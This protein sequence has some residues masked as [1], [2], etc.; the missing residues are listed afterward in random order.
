[1]NPSGLGRFFQ[2][3]G[4]GAIF[5]FLTFS[6]AAPQIIEN[7]KKPPS[8]DAG[9]VMALKEVR[10]ITDEKGKFYFVQP[11]GVFTDKAGS[12]YIQ[13]NNQL[14]KFDS[15]GRF[16]GN[17]L[18]RGQGP[19]EF[20]DNLTDVVV[21]PEDILLYSSNN[22]KLVR[23]N[24]EGRLLD[25]RKFIQG[26][27]RDLLGYRN[28]RYFFLKWE[29]ESSPRITGISEDK[30]RL[31]IV[32]EKGDII[33]AP[34]LFPLTNAKWFSSRGVAINS[35]SRVTP[36]WQGDRFVF[37]FHSPDYLI[38]LL[39]LE[40][41]EIVRIF[42][43]EYDRVKYPSKPQK[44]YPE[45]LIPKYHNDLCR[46]L[47]RNDRLWAVTSTFDP[48]KGILVDIYSREGRYLDNFYLPL[49]KI[50]R[51]DL[52]YYAPMAIHD[53]FL[54]VLEADED[55]LLSLVQYE[56]IGK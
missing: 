10:R 28:G 22:L 11:F 51:N 34:H 54:Y 39:D 9:R 19:G 32:P 53:D 7:P 29:R 40:S 49:F 6:T 17:L 44:G 1:M 12:V 52:Q 26:P 14:L 38:K 27:F 23:I 45:E 42:R 43:R 8:P 20:D 18:K 21:R 33:L 36:L 41:G 35:I 25:D 15:H 47:W 16:V 46:L 5:F 50:R 48:Q 55:D 30:Y 3:A 13:E 56:I 37:L 31:A 2:P 4:V 24:L